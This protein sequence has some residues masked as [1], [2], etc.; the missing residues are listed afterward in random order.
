LAKAAN[1][2]VSAESVSRSAA[3][4]TKDGVHTDRDEGL[5]DLQTHSSWRTS[6]LGKALRAGKIPC[7]RSL[8]RWRN[9]WRVHR[10]LQV[11]TN[12]LM[13]YFDLPRIVAKNYG[14]FFA[15]S[16]IF[17]F[18]STKLGFAYYGMGYALATLVALLM[19]VW[20]LNRAMKGMN[21]LVFMKQ[22]VQ[23]VETV[24]LDL[25]SVSLKY[26]AERF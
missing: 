5:L 2:G 17:A 19:S 13:L 8:L 18:V 16:G 12:I 22:P 24:S 1:G 11:I 26:N 20:D 3:R 14:T 9:G 25:D 21:F 10:Q 23:P 7:K 6:A 4:I 15:F